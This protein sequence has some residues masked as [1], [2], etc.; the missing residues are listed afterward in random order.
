[1]ETRQH[2]G[3]K[4]HSVLKWHDC[5]PYKPA[6]QSRPG[7]PSPESSQL[8][9]RAGQH[10]AVG[11]A[12]SRPPLPPPLSPC[13]GS[14][15]PGRPPAAACPTSSAGAL[16]VRPRPAG[17]GRARSRWG[18]SVCPAP[19][20]GRT[21]PTPWPPRASPALPTAARPPPR[22]TRKRPGSA[23]AP[24]VPQEGW[25]NIPARG[26]EAR[27]AQRSPAAQRPRTGSSGEARLQPPSLS[28]RCLEQANPPRAKQ[29]SLGQQRPSPPAR[30]QRWRCPG[31]KGRSAPPTLR[32][33]A[34]A[35]TGPSPASRS[36][37]R[38]PQC[39]LAAPGAGWAVRGAAAQ[40]VRALVRK[41]LRWEIYRCGQGPP[42]ARRIYASERGALW[43]LQRGGC[44]GWARHGAVTLPQKTPLVPEAAAP[45]SF[46][47]AGAGYCF[48][49]W[50]GML[51]RLTGRVRFPSELAGSVFW[52][53]LGDHCT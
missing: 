35:V 49:S 44:P 38:R 19:D 48:L 31:G 51:L 4:D 18:A 34:C 46:S 11:E 29:Q 12:V 30:T 50:R 22:A 39:V 33:C 41:W 42:S 2:G 27:N 40:L 6:L 16:T 45:L 13:T 9:H 20:D 23:A 8:P 43:G 5:F 3:R 24:S 1:M 26:G 7:P 28:R 47:G 15:R 17:T 36:V 37:G 53:S 14:T 32:T 52:G 10:G 25:T 21:H